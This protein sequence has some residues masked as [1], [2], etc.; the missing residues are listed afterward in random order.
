MKIGVMFGSPETTSG[1]RALKFYSSV[2]LDI[3]RIGNIKSKDQNIGTKNIV[4]VVKNKVAPP[5]RQANIEIYYNEGISQGGALL[6]A[7]T[8]FGLIEQGGAW[9]SYGKEKIGQGRETVISYLK[10]HPKIAQEI[11]AKVREKAG[12][13]GQ[14]PKITK[15]GK[16]KE[17]S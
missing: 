12:I 7:A 5:F 10:E 9:F 13:Q 2:R 8:E 11:E 3:R 1:G 17:K 16:S 14:S 15:C 4:K 6:D